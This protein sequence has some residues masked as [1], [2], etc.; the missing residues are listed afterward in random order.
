MELL[1]E[2]HEVLDLGHGQRGIEIYCRQGCCWVTVEGD[3]RDHILRAGQDCA[4]NLPGKI[5][6][7][8]LAEARLLF[9]MAGPEKVSAPFVP[10][11]GC[12]QRRR[13]LNPA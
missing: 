9:V 1:L 7:T 6:V 10:N 12:L 3:D 4:I 2:Q 5:V 11:P 8:A 13:F